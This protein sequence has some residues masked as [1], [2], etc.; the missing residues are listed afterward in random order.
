M[1]PDA[2]VAHSARLYKDSTESALVVDEDCLPPVDSLRQKLEV[3]LTASECRVNVMFTGSD[4]VQS[5]S[6][7]SC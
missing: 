5:W 2:S 4:I 7:Q 1:F 3:K 6:L